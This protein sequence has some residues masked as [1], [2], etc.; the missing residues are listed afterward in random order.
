MEPDALDTFDLDNW[1]KTFAK[2][3]NLYKNVMLST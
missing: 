2:L 3:S 1:M